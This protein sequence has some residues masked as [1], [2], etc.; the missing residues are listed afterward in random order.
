MTIVTF[1]ID[2]GKTSCSIAG[3]D[4]TGKVIFSRRIR[5][6]RLL[7][8]LSGLPP[9]IVALEA[10]GGAHPISSVMR[11]CLRHF[12]YRCDLQPSHLYGSL[13]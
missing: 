10:C 4:D 8:F 5:R 2:L 7:D 13:Q 6:F 9:C 11:W 3:I 1:G 12:P